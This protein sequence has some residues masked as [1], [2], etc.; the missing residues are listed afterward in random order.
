MITTEALMSTE[1]ALAELEQAKQRLEESRTL[2]IQQREELDRV[3]RELSIAVSER[4]TLRDQ[5]LVPAVHGLMALLGHQLTE[6]VRAEIRDLQENQS[7]VGEDRIRNIVREE[8]ESEDLLTVDQFEQDIESRIQDEIERNVEQM[9]EDK[10]DSYMHDN[11][12]DAVGEVCR[13]ELTFEVSV[14]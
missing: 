11:L 12:S 9:V 2:L 13:R 7:Q 6:L 4:S 1:S 3:K 8:L 10:I 5:K 14:N